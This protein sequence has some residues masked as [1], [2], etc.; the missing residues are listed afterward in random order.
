MTFGA[1]D[2]GVRKEM[3]ILMIAGDGF[4]IAGCVSS[5]HVAMG[6]K[7]SWRSVAVGLCGGFM[8]SEF[9]TVSDVMSSFEA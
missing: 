8:L 4:W 2:C 1:D 7:E 3:K 5:L 6:T 9:S